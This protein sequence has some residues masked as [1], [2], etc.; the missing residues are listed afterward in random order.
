MKRTSIKWALAA[1]IWLATL[2]GAGSFAY[3]QDGGAVKINPRKAA[4][5]DWSA[6]NQTTSFAAGA[7]PTSLA[8]DGQSMWVAN[9]FDATVSKLRA[10]DGA[11]LGTFKVEPE[12]SRSRGHTAPMP[13]A[14]DGA[15]IWV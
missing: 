7:G 12:Y 4:L 9:S 5:L 11:I 15:N 10:N 14:F 1:W 6:A 3:C 8:F 2:A 13:L